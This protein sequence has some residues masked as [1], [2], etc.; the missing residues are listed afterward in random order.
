M[1][2]EELMHEESIG[3]VFKRRSVCN[4]GYAQDITKQASGECIA[5][6]KVL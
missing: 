1:G 2:G 6:G 3:K 5:M 4:I